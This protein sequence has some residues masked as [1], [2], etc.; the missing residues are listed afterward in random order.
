M[1]YHSDQHGASRPNGLFATWA[2]RFASQPPDQP[3][4]DTFRQEH[5]RVCPCRLI[6]IPLCPSPRENCHAHPGFRNFFHFCQFFPSGGLLFPDFGILPV[7]R[8][9]ALPPCHVIVDE[10]PD[11]VGAIERIAPCHCALRP[12]YH[13]LPIP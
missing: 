13:M 3:S 4:Y 10:F 12:S 7:F 2:T 6:Y 5:D 9:R 11:H 8:P 1:S